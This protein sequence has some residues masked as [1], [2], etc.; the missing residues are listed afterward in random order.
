MYICINCGIINPIDY[1]NKK[2]CPVCGLLAIK[3]DKNDVAI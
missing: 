2:I 1:G 3:T